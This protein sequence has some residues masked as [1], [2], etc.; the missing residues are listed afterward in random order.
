MVGFHVMYHQIVGLTSLQSIVQMAFP[1][2]SLACIGSVHDGHLIVHDEPT[3]VTHTLG[4][5]VLA[6][7]EVYVQVI[8]TDVPYAWGNVHVHGFLS[9]SYKM[10]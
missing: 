2:V 6:F 5:D 4:Y 7:E 9:L 3:V 8:H 10:F 1:F